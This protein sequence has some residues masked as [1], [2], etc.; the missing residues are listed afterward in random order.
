MIHI[1]T[2]YNEL[3]CDAV[4]VCGITTNELRARGDKAYHRDESISEV[5]ADCPQCNP[6]PRQLGTSINQLSGRPGHPGF[7][8][9]C[10]ISRSWGYP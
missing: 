9:W 4:Y 7:D 8:K 6:H 5:A 10:E 2:D 1:R 3:N